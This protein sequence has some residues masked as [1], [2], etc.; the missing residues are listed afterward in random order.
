MLEAGTGYMYT[1]M[2][3]HVGGVSATVYAHVLLIAGK[4]MPDNA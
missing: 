3:L 1:T 4:A 2:V